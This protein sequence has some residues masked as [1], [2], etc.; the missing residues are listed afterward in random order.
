MTQVTQVKNRG[1]GNTESSPPKSRARIWTFTINNPEKNYETI[2]KNIFDT[3]TSLYVFQ[4]EKG[5]KGTVHMQGH[6]E[7][8][9]ARSLKSMKKLLPRAH[10]EKCRNRK[11]SIAYCQKDDTR[12]GGPWSKNLPKEPKP[13]KLIEKFRPWQQ[14]LFDELTNG[15]SDDRNII[16]YY[17]KDGNIGKTVFCKYMCSKYNALYC[18]G[19]A[20]D[21]KYLL[22]QYF[23]QDPCNK[24][25]LI[26]LFDYPRTIEN[27]VSYQA[28]EEIKNGIFMNTKYE[29]KMCIFNSPKVVVFANFE[30]DYEKMSKDRWIIREI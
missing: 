6:L 11:A 30:P 7:F 19:K 24:D 3:K 27:F 16:W 4:L 15:E 26:C 1:D 9:N 5:E 21:T 13:L 8:K 29:V 22:S 17:N 28:L 12:V 20:S 25:D 18:T 2:V 10:L 14:K 23:D